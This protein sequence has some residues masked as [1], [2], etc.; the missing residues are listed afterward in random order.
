MGRNHSRGTTGGSDRMGK[1]IQEN[2]EDIATIMTME[3]GSRCRRVGE[4][5]WYF[6]PRLYAAEYWPTGRR[7]LCG[8]HHARG[9]G[10]TSGSDHGNAAALLVTVSITPWNFPLSSTY[11]TVSEVIDGGTEDD[12][13]PIRL[14]YQTDNTKL[15]LLR[16]YGPMSSQTRTPLTGT[17]YKLLPNF[18]GNRE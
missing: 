2:K 16:L 3:S 7:R 6:I 4:V 5:R 12:T 1:T 9:N 18:A 14:S 10:S 17:G 8:S 13:S 15:D 11:H